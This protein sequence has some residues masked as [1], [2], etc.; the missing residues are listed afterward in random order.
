MTR[1]ACPHCQG[2][3]YA[4]RRPTFVLEVHGQPVRPAVGLLYGLL[5]AANGKLVRA[6]RLMSEMEN[7]RY[8]ASRRTLMVHICLLRKALRGSDEVI[9]NFKAMG[10]RL[11][12]AD[13]LSRPWEYAA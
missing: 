11:V 6:E 13:E 3:G 1:P 2:T 8:E 9:Q 7:L 4:D 10:Y 12:R 5:Q